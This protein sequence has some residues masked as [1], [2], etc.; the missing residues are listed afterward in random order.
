[1]NRS[2]NSDSPNTLSNN[3]LPFYY[4]VATLLRNNI[5]DGTWPPGTKLPTEHE[6]TKENGVSRPTIRN[7]KALLEKEGFIYSIKGSGCYVNG[8][9][10]WSSQLLTVENINDILHHGAKMSFKIKEFGMIANTDNI[11]QQLNNTQ[12]RFVF[13]IRG[14]RWY[15]GQPLSSVVYYL[16]FR[17][18]SRIPMESLDD[19]PF[20]PQFEKLAGIQIVEGIQ[21]ISLCKAGAKAAGHLGLK[22]NDMV[23]MVRCVY[24]DKDYQ[25]VE[26]IETKYRDKLP[27]SIRVKRN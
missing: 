9:S 2:Y 13:Q 10:N 27:Y 14:I 6:L 4:Q 5:I 22:P 25:P 8:Q 26:Y 1:M 3:P 7:A 20:I 15:K 18:G 12:D 19:N 23:L 24:F 16:P 11:K 17:F 21:N